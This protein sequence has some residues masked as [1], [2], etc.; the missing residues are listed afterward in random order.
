MDFVLNAPIGL[1]VMIALVAGGLLFTG[2]RSGREAMRNTA[3]IMLLIAALLLALKWTVPTDE[4]KV[5]KT[6]RELLGAIGSGDWGKAG[7]LLKHAA[8][9]GWQ[10]DDLAAQAEFAAKHYNLTSIGI[11]TLEVKREPLVMSVRTS[12]TTRHEGKEYNSVPSTWV[13]EYQKRGKDW[14][15]TRLTPIKIFTFQGGDLE[16][17]MQARNW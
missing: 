1:L 2:L 3:F 6:T 12:V 15:L 10:G 17:I 4:K 9:F 8:L 13:F 5:E 14:V 16:S 11:N 7:P